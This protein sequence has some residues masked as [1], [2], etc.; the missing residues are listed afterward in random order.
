MVRI[1]SRPDIEKR[2]VEWCLVLA[3]GGRDI[4][5]NINPKDENR[6]VEANPQQGDGAK[7]AILQRRR[8]RNQPASVSF[9]SSGTSQL[10][11]ALAHAPSHNDDS[12]EY[13]SG[14]EE[15]GYF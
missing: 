2:F 12:D 3:S 10:Q 4:F 13:L 8:N 1:Y 7:L 15:E 9:A 11:S 5:Q 6:G 14:S